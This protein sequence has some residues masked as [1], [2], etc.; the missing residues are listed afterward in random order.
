V[1]Q[2]VFTRQQIDQRAEVQNLVTGPRRPCQ[3]EFSGD[4]GDTALF[5]RLGAAVR[6]NGDRAVFPDKLICVGSSVSIESRRRP[7]RSRRSGF[8][9]TQARAKSDTSAAPI[10]RF[11]HLAKDVHVGF[12]PGPEQPA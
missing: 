10:D 6:R 9:F 8:H 4:L 3:L 5:I 2:A 11:L 12:L 7:C 1:Q